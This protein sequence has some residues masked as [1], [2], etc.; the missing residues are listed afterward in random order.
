M[1]IG[2]ILPNGVPGVR[3][4]TV[5]EWARRADAGPFST[6]A[7]VDRLNYANLDPLMTL[8][9]A[10]GVTCRAKLMTYIAIGGLRNPAVFAKE[11]A[12][13][14]VLSEGRLRLGLGVGAR[15][16]DYEVSGQAWGRRGKLLD[17]A[18]EAVVGLRER[19][20][21]HQSLGPDLG[22]VE[23]LVGGSSPPAL[24]R[25]VAHGHG[26]CHGGVN[27]EIFGYEVMA[28]NGAWQGAGRAGSPKVVA[29]T[30]YCS[31]DSGPTPERAA[32]WMESYFVQGAPPEPI[33]DGVHRGRAA[34]R[35][36][37]EAFAAKGAQEVVFFPCVDDL[38]ELDWLAE[39]IADLA[40]PV[41]APRAATPSAP[42][43]VPA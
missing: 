8:A 10:A 9:A 12:S 42:A 28:V 4:S 5:L 39:T 21:A 18:L 26:Y 14:S 37:V 7:A 6:I 30:W 34:V 41:P 31:T 27:A 32:S 35:E 43:G 2:V 15:P 25:I 20:D 1:Q 19:P 40:D 38:S 17:A 13:L 33:R 23:I 11:V 22:D 16:A 3:G 29:S 36:A 24:E